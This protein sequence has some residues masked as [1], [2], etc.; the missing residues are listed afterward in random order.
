MKTYFVSRHPGAVEWARRHGIQA[1]QLH[2]LDI[3]RICK[4][5]IVIGTLPVNLAEKVCSNGARYYHLSLDLPFEARA[6][7]LSAEEMTRF[8]ARLE[9]F[10][11][12]KI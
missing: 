12:R 2:H 7:E 1:L 6:R 8:N 5:D 4:G 9:E 3:D 11:V 10:S